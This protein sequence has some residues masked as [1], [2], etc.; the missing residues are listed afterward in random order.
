MWEVV[1]LNSIENI[2]RPI[3]SVDQSDLEFLIPAENDTYMDLNIRLFVRG[4][5]TTTN[6][7]SLEETDYIAVTNNFLHSLFS[8]C[9]LTLNG[10]TIT[11]TTELYQY[12]SYLET[13]LTYG[14]DAATSHLTNGFWYLE[15]G[16]LQTCDPT[17]AESRN[18]GFISRWT[19]VKQSKE[20]QLLGRLHSDICSVFPY[21]LPGVELQIKLTKGKR[22]FYLMNTKANSISKFQF[23]EEYLIFNRIR[24][25][26][27]YLI[28][29]NTT[30]AKGGLARYNMT[31]VELKTFTYS[32]GPKSLSID[33]A[34]LGQLPKRLLFTMIKKKDFLGSLDINPYYFQNFNL[35]HFTLFYNGKPIP[36][37][38]LAMN[39]AQEKTSDLAYNYSKDRAYVTR[40]PG[41][42]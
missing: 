13:L 36:S 27:A 7:K 21:L 5:L 33:N 17:K 37:E 26:L 31:R 23:L 3:A 18:T 24:P 22:A 25:N 32:A 42:N 2:F 34:V 9:S 4:K 40:T 6:G 38:G 35:S 41:C 19:L 39:M 20:V 15:T 12:R 1:G 10:T 8:Q 16:D 11:K 14:S 30:L 29:R 28:A